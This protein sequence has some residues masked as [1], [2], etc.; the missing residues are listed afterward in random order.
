MIT[1]EQKNII[2]KHIK[3]YNPSTIGLFGSYARNENH[4]NSDLDILVDFKQ[5]VNLLDLIG[6]EQDLSD[7]LGI[8][9]DLVTTQSLHPEIKKYVEKD[10]QFILND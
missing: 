4:K 10:I 8:K 3:P 5:T 9:V 6:L 7:L 1:A 2:I